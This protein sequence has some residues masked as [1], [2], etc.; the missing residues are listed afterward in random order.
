MA[1]SEFKYRVQDEEGIIQFKTLQEALVCIQTDP[2]KLG[3]IVENSSG[4]V[5]TVWMRDDVG[6]GNV[7]RW[8]TSPEF[9]HDV[10]FWLDEIE[11]QTVDQ[12]GL[13]K[14]RRDE[15]DAVARGRYGRKI[16]E[17]LVE[18]VDDLM[19]DQVGFP[20][21]AADEEETV[22]RMSEYFWLA[23]KDEYLDK[24]PEDKA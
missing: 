12:T 14:A 2:E 4:K 6:L 18:D 15:L 20:F 11:R 22:D 17:K 8:N 16:W 21:D 3:F 10:Q 7:W 1:E 13:T 5:V 19:R 23:F 9:K 24:K